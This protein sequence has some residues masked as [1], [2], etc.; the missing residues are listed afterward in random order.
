[1]EEKVSE[2]TG[3]R[4]SETDRR[5]ERL[6]KAAGKRKAREPADVRIGRELVKPVEKKSRKVSFC[7]GEYTGEYSSSNRVS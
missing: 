3:K 7:L 4:A 6:N 5:A 1:M 2:D